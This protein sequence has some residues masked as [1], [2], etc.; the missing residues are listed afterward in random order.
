M[1][2]NIIFQRICNDI[3]FIRFYRLEDIPY[4]GVICNIMSYFFLRS[5]DS[6]RRSG[7]LVR[8]E[9]GVTRTGTM[10]WLRSHRQGRLSYRSIS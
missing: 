1:E 2:Y 4:S 3:P 6:P 5:A 8:D 10:R 9:V 7:L